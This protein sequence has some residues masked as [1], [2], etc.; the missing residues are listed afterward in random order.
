VAAARN[1]QID[2]DSRRLPQN[3]KY[4]WLEIEKRPAADCQMGIAHKL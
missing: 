1:D 4:L 2:S 3:F